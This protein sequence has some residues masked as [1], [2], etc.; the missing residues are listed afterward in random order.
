MAFITAAGIFASSIIPGTILLTKRLD[1]GLAHYLL[2]PDTGVSSQSAMHLA[3]AVA[4][5]AD[6]VDELPDLDD[7]QSV[8]WLKTERMPKQLRRNTANSSPGSSPR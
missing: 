8:V 4:A 1:S 5:R 3:P 2:A 6:L 7:V